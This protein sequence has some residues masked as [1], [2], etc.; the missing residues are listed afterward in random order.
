MDNFIVF[1]MTE[2]SDTLTPIGIV[3]NYIS[4]MYTKYAADTGSFELC[5]PYSQN[6]LDLVK[7][8]NELERFILFDDNIIGICQKV[9][10]IIDVDE[11]KIMV[12]GC[13]ANGILDN[14][15]VA[16]IERLKTA[17]SSPQNLLNFPLS[18]QYVF[19]NFPDNISGGIWSGINYN[20][21]SDYQ[22]QTWDFAD[23]YIGGR[24]SY[25]YYIKNCVRQLDKCYSLDF[26]IANNNFDL[27][28]Y[29]PKDR[30]V[31]QNQNS[32]AIISTKFGDIL[33]S[34]YYLNTKNYKNI[35]VA[36][37]IIADRYYE[38]I[39]TYDDIEILPSYPMEKRKV[40]YV[41]II[42]VS[43]ADEDGNELSEQDILGLLKQKGKEELYE[44]ALI[45]EYNCK[46]NQ[47]TKFKL[48]IDFDLGDK[49][50]IQDSEMDL[51]LDAKIT[52]Y[53]KTKSLN[54]ETFE[55]IVG[56]PQPTLTQML[57]RKGVI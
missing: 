41:E 17:A 42:D 39:V 10:P 2:N 14:Y 29:S 13:L 15:S 50:T 46:L 36:Y 7:R 32:P 20:L 30:T 8:T 35:I 1:E 22:D 37:A 21:P 28:I 54:G 23:G 33:S 5:L 44:Y 31:N 55:P 51:L 48:G 3:E 24:C 40:A 25:E 16:K 57:K 34:Q 6:I 52:G 53:T 43:N 18:L 38:Q 9:N 56:I 45:S 11:R 26:N 49:I 47:N 27:N 12:Q 4:L 19:Q